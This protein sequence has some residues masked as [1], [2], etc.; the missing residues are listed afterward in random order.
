MFANRSTLRLLLPAMVLPVCV[1]LSDEAAVHLASASGWSQQATLSVLAWLVLQTALLS[2][3]AGAKLPTWPWR[4]IL[5][6][7]TLLLVNALQPG[8]TTYADGL[9]R[10][11][12]LERMLGRAFL[13]GEIAFIMVWLVLGDMSL[14]RRLALA[15]LGSLPATYLGLA[16]EFPSY[17]NP[18]R[19]DGN[20]A[21]NVIV[22]V[23]ISSVGLIAGVLRLRG[24]RIEPPTKSATSGS[25]GPMQFSIRHLIVA[26]TFAAILTFGAQRAVEASHHTLVSGQWVHASV[27]GV[28]LSLIALTMLWMV[29][30]AGRWQ[31]KVFVSA[32]LA[33][34]VG[35]AID[36]LE[37][38][39]RYGE[40]WGH[41]MPL[42]DMRALWPA[43]TSLTGSFLAGLL[44]MLRA[45]GFRLV[46]G[47]RR[48]Q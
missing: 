6:G 23:Q 15:L 1:V 34:G 25:G 19:Y 48:A 31:V 30:G 4:L 24:F 13:S 17:P 40:R 3:V 37:S 44:L 39:I 18:A 8:L 41:R 35:A 46:K 9:N 42:T 14:M 16:L 21:W 29:L 36:W 26:T 5:L 38:N 43:W 33:A 2:H 28:L 27:V 7:W 12:S 47:T 20:G 22:I 11:E 32:M 10:I 45:T